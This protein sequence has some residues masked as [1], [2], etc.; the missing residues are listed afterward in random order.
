MNTS[1]TEVHY[2][3]YYCQTESN[4]VYKWDTSE[5]VTCPNN[6]NHSIDNSSVTIID[7]VSTNQVELVDAVRTQF[8]E[9][10]GL[11]KQLLLNLPSS[12]GMTSLRDNY[13]TV[14]DATI[15]NN[16]S[17]EFQLLSIGPT[18]RAS[19]TSIERAPCYGHLTSEACFGVRIPRALNSNQYIKFGLYD[20]GSSNG[21]FFKFDITGMG[22]GFLNGVNESN[23]SQSNLNVD[24]LDGNGLSGVSFQPSKGYVYGLRV[25]GNGP[26]AVEYG[27]YTKSIYGDH[28]FCV[29]HRLYTSDLDDKPCLQTNLP[30]TIEAVNNG[31]GGSN[32]VYLSDRSFVVYGDVQQSGIDVREHRT[33]NL[34]VPA[35]SINTSDEFVPIASLRKKS[36]FMGVNAYL[37]SIDVMCSS[38]Q[39]LM[40]TSGSTLTGP[41]W[42]P[43]PNQIESE[44]AV[45]HDVSSAVIA[46]DGIV[47]WQGL[48]PS[49]NIT[50]KLPKQLMNGTSAI[51]ISA[52]NVSSTG[53]MTLVL[54]TSEAW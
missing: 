19:I 37:E 47:L 32:V 43:L 11:N 14:G 38:P 8:Q 33:N 26:R 1:T 3:R 49:G 53:T 54:R 31:I 18:D 52:R 40:L 42:Q 27:L 34:F 5:P 4:F 24:A 23:V 22:I 39:L 21:A 7:T 10:L 28:R 2:Y 20:R 6:H 50:C 12:V 45:E 48:A 15:L 44:T 9:S 41:S 17:R 46:N 25:S 51:T 35:V 13:V 36:A 30:L 29:M 16:S